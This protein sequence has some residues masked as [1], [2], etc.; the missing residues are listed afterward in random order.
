MFYFS[1]IGK[2]FKLNIWFSKCKQ[3]HGN[4]FSFSGLIKLPLPGTLDSPRCV[5]KNMQQKNYKDHACGKVFATSNN[6]GALIQTLHYSQIQYPRGIPSQTGAKPNISF[7][8]FHFLYF[9]DA[10]GRFQITL[11]WEIQRFV[12]NFHFKLSICIL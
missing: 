12:S 8:V 7:Y 1:I 10:W 5:I 3:Q 9:E 4:V 11:S 2:L 6:F